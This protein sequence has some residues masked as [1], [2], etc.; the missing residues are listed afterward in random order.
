L[1]GQLAALSGFDSTARLV[2]LRCPTPIV[3]GDED[4]VV[5]PKNAES[6]ARQIAGARH[7]SLG[8][9]GHFWWAHRTVEAA[10]LLA[11]FLQI[12]P[13]SLEMGNIRFDKYF[14]GR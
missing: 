7:V 11:S 13:G 10:D 4:A 14:H 1:R 9:A 5:P 2:E 3:S 6:L 8:G 12:G